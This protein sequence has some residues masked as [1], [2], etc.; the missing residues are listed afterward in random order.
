MG[1][2]LGLSIL[3]SS[4]GS[5]SGFDM[6]V[7][8]NYYRA[9]LPVAPSAQTSRSKPPPVSVQFAPWFQKSPLTTNIAKLNDAM[10][11]KSFVDL[12]DASI[13]KP[14]VDNDHKKLFALYKGLVRLQALANRSSE[15]T[16]LAGERNGLNTRF[17]AG[18]QEIRTF[19]SE[20]GF[21]DLSV[22]FGAQ[23]SRV[24]TGFRKLRTP[25][26]YVAPTIVVGQST[27][28]IAGLTGTE[29]FTVT[30]GR[31]AGDV[32]VAMDLSEIT[33]AISVDSLIAY[34]NGKLEQAG[35]VSRFNKTVENGRSV[36]DPK[37]ISLSIQTVATERLSFAAEIAKPAIYVGSVVGAA[38]DRGGLLSKLTD[39]GVAV[40]PTFSRKLTVTGGAVDVRGTA[41]DMQ[42][43]VYVVGSTTENM[44]G[45]VVQGS[46]DVYLR[47]YDGAGQ[48]VWSRL[49][50]SSK[51]AS[52]FAVATDANG[53]VAIAGRITDR[54]TAS[55]VGGGGDSF[56]AKFDASGKEVFSRQVAP[57]TDDSANALAFSADGSLVVAGQT[58]ST[59]SLSVVHG[60][61]TDAYLMKLS[62]S[63]NL[64]WVRQ[65]GGASSDRATGV[66]VTADG[67]AVMTSVEGGEAIVRK[68]GLGD[69]ISEPAW[70]V[71]LGAIGQGNIGAVAIEGSAVYIA[72]STS[73]PGL[74]AGGAATIVSSHS[75]DSDGFVSKIVDQGTS[76]AVSYTTYVG[77]SGADSG[78]GLAVSNGA[79]YV[80]GATM[81]SLD[82]ASTNTDADA[83]VRKL[84]AAGAAVWTHQFQSVGSASAAN[85][86]SVDAQGASVLDR[87]GLPRGQISFDESRLITAGS[88]VR[89]GDHFF[90]R[91]NDGNKLKINVDAGDTMRSLAL[92]IN[93]AML[94]KGSAEVS[95][96]GGDGIR[97]T[98]KE[99]N[100]V[101]LI[102]GSAGL[103]A[104][105]GLGLEPMKLDANKQTASTAASLRRFSLGL[106]TG[107]N[108][109]EKL[110]SKTMVYQ[111]GSA[112]EVVKLAYMTIT[113]TSLRSGAQLDQRALNSYQSALSR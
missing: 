53:N 12:T 79:V 62:T 97:I 54:L 69:G 1:G 24:D 63:G 103:D 111:L 26:T 66:A 32:A 85:A 17:Q 50:G 110:R 107:M 38:K 47:K 52:G 48:L 64:E 59:F 58:S 109:E 105:A 45:G 94:L 104:L 60:G 76:A 100:T 19:L 91:V 99:G 8:T 9:K 102:A 88:S 113:G 95:R 36:S 98:A 44:S 7:L 30:V 42:G 37:R 22:G 82:G 20:K 92:K 2:L 56:V 57:V 21:D 93:N 73:N 112:I 78:L 11:T 75:G 46:Q 16:V 71:N 34:M 23:V 86:I 41:T 89:A 87:L 31:S 33:G 74:D 5:G 10:A 3:S 15:D 67:H 84:D 29:K 96:T 27:D 81:G 6:S 49:L 83:Y 18:L 106:E 61:G 55:A 80:S 43:N 70:S 25:S 4:S 35:V 101:E 28:A 51:E 72:G 13:N 65:F 39:D 68:V 14:G 90:L 40:S 77:T 108:L